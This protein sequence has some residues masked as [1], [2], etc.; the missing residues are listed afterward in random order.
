MPLDSR[1][2]HPC[3]LSPPEHLKAR[4]RTQQIVLHLSL[5]FHDPIAFHT[6]HFH[7]KLQYNHSQLGVLSTTFP[8]SLDFFNVTSIEYKSKPEHKFIHFVPKIT[9]IQIQ[10][11][12]SLNVITKLNIKLIL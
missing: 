5:N 9:P 2:D 8:W 1:C 12:R 6:S 11:S 10:C 7:Q 3:C 4:E